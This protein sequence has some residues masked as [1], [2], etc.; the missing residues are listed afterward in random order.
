MAKNLDHK[1][2]YLGQLIVLTDHIDAQ[3][4]TV[5]A[6]GH[7]DHRLA[8]LLVWFEG[9]RLSSQWTDYYGSRLPTMK[10]IERSIRNGRLANGQDITGI[11][12]KEAA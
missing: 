7:P 5:G 12:S 4:Y 8:I 9:S 6:I 11:L 10:Q 2:L 1:D 3:V